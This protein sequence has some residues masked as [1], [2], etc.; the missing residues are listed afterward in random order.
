MKL[1]FPTRTTARQFA[2]KSDN[3]K[4]VDNGK[5]SAKRW[6]VSLKGVALQ[7]GSLTSVKVSRNSK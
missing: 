5:E 6:A 2:S 4:V 1:F 3:K 7:S